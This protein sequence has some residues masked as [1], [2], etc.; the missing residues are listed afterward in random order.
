MLSQVM[1]VKL[2]AIAQ[3][4]KLLT[5]RAENVFGLSCKKDQFEILDF[6]QE[7]LEE[8]AN[9]ICITLRFDES[10]PEV[11]DYNYHLEVVP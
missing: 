2:N 8:L 7:D 11:L 1:S 3:L 5:Q 9:I 4:G 6:R 10:L